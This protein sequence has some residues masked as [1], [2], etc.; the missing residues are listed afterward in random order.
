VAGK[1]QGGRQCQ[2]LEAGAGTLAASGA[3]GRDSYLANGGWRLCHGLTKGVLDRHP[4]PSVTVWD[5]SGDIVGMGQN[6]EV[7]G[8]LG[9]LLSWLD[10]NHQNLKF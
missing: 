3:R 6:F 9:G 2:N 8:N 4:H 5:L 1:G 10:R 7:D